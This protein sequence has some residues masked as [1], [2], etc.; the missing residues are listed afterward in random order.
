MSSMPSKFGVNVSPEQDR[1]NPKTPEEQT[2]YQQPGS[3]TLTPQP[4]APSFTFIDASQVK[5]RRDPEF[6]KGDMDAKAAN[7]SF[8]FQEG[9]GTPPEGTKDYLK[10]GAVRTVARVGETLAGLPG[11]IRNALESV[12]AWGAGKITGDE[13]GV[14]ALRPIVRALSPMGNLPTAGEIRK[15]ITQPLSQLAAGD[16]QYAE[17]QTGGEQLYDDF[18]SDVAALA[19]PVK[20]KIPFARALGTAFF[21]NLGKEAAEAM[22]IDGTA[23][24]FVKLGSMALAGGI[25]EAIKRGGARAYAKDLYKQAMDAV[26]QG[27]VMNTRDMQAGLGRFLSS[28]NKGGVTAQKEPVLKLARQL[29]NKINAGNGQI[30]VEELPAFRR[31][32]ND[33]RYGRE[34]NDTGRFFLD[35]F[36]SVL[37]KGLMEYGKTNPTFLSK[38]RDAN[39]AF[40]GFQQSNRIA[41][42]ISKKYDVSKLSPETM[43]LLGMHLVTPKTLLGIAGGMT[44]AKGVQLMHRFTNNPVLQRYYMD[45]VKSALTDDAAAL[46]KNVSRLDEAVRED[47]Q[48]SKGRSENGL[49][50]RT[51]ETSR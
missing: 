50:G 29:Q 21:G 36:D 1:N 7:N 48:K 44:A 49:S 47:D 23:A 4:K 35:Q 27:A 24:N 13:E 12:V 16:S 22:G 9:K 25:G 11:D 17:P 46:S 40:Q 42:Y 32:V 34:L 6:Q 38:Y 26:P 45:V 10:R 5:E 18:V 39:T 37:N 19:V 20:G 15:G 43:V 30:A 8:R 33:L 3:N 2:R 28:V 41:R 31:S 51:G 14:D